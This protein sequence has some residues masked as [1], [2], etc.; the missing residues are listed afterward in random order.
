MGFAGNG[1]QKLN[2]PS[3]DVNA[4]TAIDRTD[5]K[6]TV[7]FPLD[8]P[9]PKPAINEPSQ[10]GYVGALRQSKAKS[11]PS[12]ELAH[13]LPQLPNYE[14]S[15]RAAA[16]SGVTKVGDDTKLNLMAVVVLSTILSLVT[17][18]IV[19]ALVVILTGRI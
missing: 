12:R 10:Q 3:A 17:C 15:I 13:D 9:D 1:R 5:G 19:V 2:N 14:G 8:K 4:D 11:G 18:I 7:A 16:I 6:V